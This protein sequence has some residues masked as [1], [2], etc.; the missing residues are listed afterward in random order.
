MVRSLRT[1]LCAGN[2]H[3]AQVAI[4]WMNHDFE[5]A[6]TGESSE[7]QRWSITF[8]SRPVEPAGSSPSQLK[9]SDVPPVPTASGGG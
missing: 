4:R 5:P 6:I 7:E 2:F 3:S 8:V 1:L 9:R